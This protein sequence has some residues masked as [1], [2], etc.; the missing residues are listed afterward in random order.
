M[1]Q[2]KDLFKTFR[3]QDVLRGVNLE[4]PR[5][6]ITVIL[7]TSGEGKT[8]LL[9][10]LI[11]FY[12]PDRGQ[13]VI[14]GTDIS[15]LS[16]TELNDFRR[17]FGMLFQEGALFDSLTVGENIAFPLREHTSLSEAEISKKVRELLGHVSLEGAE[18]K[19]P[20]ELS[21][22][23]RKRVG[24]ARAIALKPQII[25]YD[26]PTTGLDPLM[27]R[28]INKLI[29]DMEKKFGVTSVI[30]SHDIES[31]LSMGH[32]IAMLHEGKIIE[33]GAPQEFRVSRHPFVRE[34]LSDHP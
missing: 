28:S 7:G 1:I 30:I 11:G 14:E 4:I 5:G 3:D 24:L 18:Q 26:E 22:G 2:I 17:R 32:K 21:G 31:A 9:K 29:L 25:L 20:A 12:R 19:M 34:F 33:E 27:T 6:K 10:H 16:E 13:V 8:V 23:M 15:R